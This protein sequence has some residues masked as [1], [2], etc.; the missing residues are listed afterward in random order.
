[1]SCE[2]VK[3]GDSGIGGNEEIPAIALRRNVA[4]ID[5]CAVCLKIAPTKNIRDEN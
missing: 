5:A 3:F 2:P 4:R 1:M